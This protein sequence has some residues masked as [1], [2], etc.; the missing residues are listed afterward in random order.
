MS[1]T[2]E[3]HRR[4]QLRLGKDWTY[5]VAK[6][7]NFVSVVNVH[8]LLGSSG[9]LSLRRGK[10]VRNDLETL[11]VVIFVSDSKQVLHMANM[12]GS[13]YTI[14]LNYQLVFLVMLSQR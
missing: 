13:S 11:T 7:V 5:P 3:L 2:Q 6:G 14:T 4:S 12:I 10:P 8:A 1:E 9:I